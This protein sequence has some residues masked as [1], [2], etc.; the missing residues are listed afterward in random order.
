MSDSATTVHV[1]GAAIVADGQCLVARRGPSMPLA[2]KWEF[3]GG[4]VEPGESIADALVREIAEELAITVAVGPWLG[5]GTAEIVKAH[6]IVRVVLDVH[7]A[8][9]RAGSLTPA[10]HDRISWC[11][12]ETL[13]ALD[14]AEADIPI[15]PRVAARLAALSR[16]QG[17]GT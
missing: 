7:E 15:V 14:W 12:P 6:R 17:F 9:W 1:V 11:T 2:G 8:Y 3:P 16:G 10:E 4:K 13:P 5:R